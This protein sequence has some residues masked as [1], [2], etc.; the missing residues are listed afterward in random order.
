MKRVW[1]LLLAMLWTITATGGAAIAR[2]AGP[3]LSGLKGLSL[4]GFTRKQS[5]KTANGVVEVWQRTADG[6]Q[7][8]IEVISRANLA[9]AEKRLNAINAK[10][11]KTEP[12]NEELLF[13]IATSG[14]NLSW[15]NYRATNHVTYKT[16]HYWRLQSGTLVMAS[17]SFTRGKPNFDEAR[18]AFIAAKRAADGTVKA[19]GL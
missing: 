15:A 13:R 8:R 7:L 11:P 9:L 4:R 6:A 19:L 18:G 16:Y 3:N 1:A 14:N 12:Q 17:V 2:Q 10:I 5:K